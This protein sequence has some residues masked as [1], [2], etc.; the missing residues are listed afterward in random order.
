MAWQ[1]AE[2]ECM[3]WG[4]NLASITSVEERTL[5]GLLYDAFGHEPGDFLWVG[6]K[7]VLEGN[8]DDWKWTDANEMD[9]S[10][11]FW[12]SGRPDSSAASGTMD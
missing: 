1:E 4:G 9:T 2:D 10:G 11:T 6:A 12:E 7:D 3:R 5:V 8:N